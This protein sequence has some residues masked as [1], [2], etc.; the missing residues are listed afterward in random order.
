MST[1]VERLSLHTPVYYKISIQV[2][3]DE[4]WAADLGMVLTYP[5]DVKK[6]P[7]TILN[8]Q[9]ADQAALLGLLNRLYGLGL[10]LLL[11]EY[12]ADSG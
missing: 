9:L 1:Q 3:L 6:N 2:V 5:D 8:G 12:V 7:V 4:S 11:V 10:P